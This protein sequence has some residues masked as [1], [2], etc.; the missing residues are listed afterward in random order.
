MLFTIHLADQTLLG[1]EEIHDER[2]DRVLPPEAQPGEIAV[3]ELAPEPKSASGMRRRIRL[4]RVLFLGETSWWEMT[5]SRTS[6]AR[7]SPNS[8]L[9]ARGRLGW[10]SAPSEWKSADPPGGPTSLR[11]QVFGRLPQESDRL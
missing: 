9:P 5:P 10:Q 11:Q 1:T 8:D 4:A 2:P 6:A 7:R 3:P